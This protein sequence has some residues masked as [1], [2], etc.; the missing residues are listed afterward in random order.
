MSTGGY[1]YAIRCAEFV[2]FG[3]SRNPEYRLGEIQNC[4]P[5]ECEIVGLSPADGKQTESAV[6][7][8][9]ASHKH[10]GEWFIYS[11]PVKDYVAQMPLRFVSVI[12]FSSGRRWNGDRG[13]IVEAR[14]A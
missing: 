4:T 5:F 12:R 2:K 8:Q 13:K 10:R 3:F 1:I 14:V 7:R 11:G 6:H 9:F